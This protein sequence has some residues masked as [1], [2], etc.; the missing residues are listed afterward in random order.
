MIFCTAPPTRREQAG[1]PISARLPT[2]DQRVV[3]TLNDYLGGLIGIVSV[4]GVLVWAY[5]V[6]GDDTDP[7]TRG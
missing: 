2:G 5:Q 6:M 4:I 1:S 3:V 7:V